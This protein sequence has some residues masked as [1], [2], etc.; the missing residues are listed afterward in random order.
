MSDMPD[1]DQTL[2]SRDQDMLTRESRRKA[3]RL[4]L[5]VLKR[6]RKNIL[7]LGIVFMIALS[8]YHEGGGT[9]DWLFVF[10]AGLVEVS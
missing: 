1:I 7:H 10:L 6:R 2:D 5:A 3:N 9:A 8:L 4:R